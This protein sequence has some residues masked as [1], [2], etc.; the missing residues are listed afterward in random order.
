[1]YAVVSAASKRCLQMFADTDWG[2]MDIRDPGAHHCG[3]PTQG[4]RTR[5][6]PG[7]RLQARIAASGCCK[8]R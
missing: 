3:R 4:F 1:M 8:A 5:G 7:E 6:S 2:L